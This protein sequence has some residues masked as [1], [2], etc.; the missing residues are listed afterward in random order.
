MAP[1]S[2]P[3]GAVCTR[4]ASLGSAHPRHLATSSRNRVVRTH[5]RVR[6]APSSVGAPL[7]GARAGSGRVVHKQRTF[8]ADPTTRG[9]W[10][11]VSW[12][13]LV[14]NAR[15]DSSAH[16]ATSSVLGFRRQRSSRMPRLGI[17][18]N[19]PSSGETEH[20]MRMQR[21]LATWLAVRLRGPRCSASG[22]TS[23][24]PA[25]MTS[26]APRPPLTSARADTLSWIG[27]RTRSFRRA[28]THHRRPRRR[29]CRTR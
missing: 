1:C 16:A 19:R 13:F 28:R 23:R 8:A 4:A 27:P 11:L 6:R 14:P 26:P 18:R 15:M 29:G 20:R 22:R 9:T 12:P 3:R 7:G 24:T 21:R 5:A 17:P 10:R 25:T 2:W